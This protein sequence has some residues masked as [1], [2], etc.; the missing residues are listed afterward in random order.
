MAPL[1]HSL[2]VIR[3]LTQLVLWSWLWCSDRCLWLETSVLKSSDQ[4]SLN[5]LRNLSE[6]QKYAGVDWYPDQ[7]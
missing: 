7:W 3:S 4:V 1:G 5:F 6:Y 2:W